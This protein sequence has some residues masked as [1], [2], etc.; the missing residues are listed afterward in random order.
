MM[1]NEFIERTGYEP[2][3]EEYHY[4]EESYYE[5]AC[6]DKN[7]F[8]KQWVKDNASGK[9]EMELR[10]RKML[11]AQKEDYETR[12]KDLVETIEF[13][14]PY[15]DKAYHAEKELR[16]ANKKLATMKL[17]ADRIAQIF[18]GECQIG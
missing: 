2:S 17:H 1:R 13:Y 10:Y 14:R 6:I 7:E 15:Y 3:T 5:S 18:T 11:D 8:C 16:E 4:I 12:L 9:W